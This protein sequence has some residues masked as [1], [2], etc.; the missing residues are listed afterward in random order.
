VLGASAVIARTE[1]GSLLLDE[2]GPGRRFRSL[3]R[4]ARCIG[5]SEQTLSDI[6]EPPVPKPGCQR[7]D[8]SVRTLEKLAVFLDEDMEHVIHWHRSPFQGQEWFPDRSL[9]GEARQAELTPE[10]K[11]ALGRMGADGRHHPMTD[12]RQLTLQETT[13]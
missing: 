6:I 13:G 8:P 1:L 10:E 4:M 7:Y 2:V 5:I 3:A 9:G 11:S 12:E